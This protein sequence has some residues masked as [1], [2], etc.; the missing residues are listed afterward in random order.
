MRVRSMTAVTLPQAKALVDS[1]FPRQ[2]PVERMFFWAWSRRDRPV[3]KVLLA[4][5]GVKD[6]GDFWVAL[7][8]DDGVVGTVGLYRNRKDAHEAL[9]LSWFCVSPELR[10]TGLGGRLLDF[11]I[12][13]ARASGARYLRLY[14]GDDPIMAKAQHVY[15]SRGLRIYKTLNLIRVRVIYRQLELV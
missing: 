14:T 8:D 4:V 9:W 13:R 3:V 5:V 2:G 15:E 11:A 1:I 12:E 6:L 10:G 7:D